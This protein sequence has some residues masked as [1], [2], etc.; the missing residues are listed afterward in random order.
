M[1]VHASPVDESKKYL[2]FFSRMSNPRYQNNTRRTQIRVQNGIVNSRR[3]TGGIFQ[4]GNNINTFDRTEK[5][6]MLTCA[7]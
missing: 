7:K 5:K 2:F 3:T 4:V 6:R 1:P